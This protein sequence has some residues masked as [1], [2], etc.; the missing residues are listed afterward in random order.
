MD[1]V[2]IIGTERSGTNL[3]RLIL[4]S[5]SGI[6]IPHPPHIMKN[7]S[8]LEPFYGD[9][10]AD[11]NFKALIND[12]VSMVEL[13]PYPWE[14]R[15]DREE[16]F[17][18]SCGRD[19]ISVFFAIYAQYLKKSGKK[20]W[21]CKS[22]FMLYHVAAIRRY[23]PHA[24][25]LYMVRDG[26]DVALSAKNSIFNHYCVYYTAGLW[27]KEQRIG[28]SWLKNL[29][30]SDI[31]VV[32]YE[33]LLGDPENSLKS[34]CGFLEEP[35][36]NRMLDFSGE[37]EAKKSG[38]ISISW[39]NTARP[40]ISDN[41][42]KFRKGLN[43]RE[44]MVFEAIAKEEMEYF[45]YPLENIFSKDAERNDA[46]AFKIWYPFGEIFLMLQVQVRHILSDRN[47]LLRFKKYLFLNFVRFSR[48]IKWK[49]KSGNMR[50]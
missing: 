17:R 37:Q 39:K 6:S 12:V 26:R 18:Q 42:G 34:I 41:A 4:N 31:M 23:Y 33:D 9:L 15:L 3:L 2:F 20:R 27:K 10:G 7:F 45:S 13:H 46:A 28:I 48:L 8:T 36:E 22:T 25:F 32:K 29:T 1:P 40:I 5:H 30:S 38:S 11:R 47:N 21:G 44:I 24:K 35:F 14:I 50:K 19:L 43:T 49:M 16:V